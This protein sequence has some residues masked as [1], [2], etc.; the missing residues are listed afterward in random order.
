MVYVYTVTADIEVVETGGIDYKWFFGCLEIFNNMVP[1]HTIN[2]LGLL[3]L[4]G[5]FVRQFSFVQINFSFSIINK[6]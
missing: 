3:A 6:Y 4:H 5:I 2:M 1:L